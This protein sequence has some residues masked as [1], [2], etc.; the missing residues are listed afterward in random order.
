[1]NSQ[2]IPMERFVVDT[3]ILPIAPPGSWDI[4]IANQPYDYSAN[5]EEFRAALTR[6]TTASTRLGPLPADCTLT[7]ALEFKEDQE[8]PEQRNGVSFNIHRSTSV[9]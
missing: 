5:Q 6:L 1:M 9:V 2:D 4:P 7:V 8:P 3:A